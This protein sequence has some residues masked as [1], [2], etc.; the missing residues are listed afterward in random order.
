MHQIIADLSGMGSRVPGYVGHRRAFEYVKQHFEQIG[1]EDIEVE[2]HTVT[3]PI[4]KGASLTLADTG[5]EIA[6]Y[7]FGPTIYKR[8]LY[9]V[10]GFRGHLFMGARGHFQNSMAKRSKAALS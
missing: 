9:P 8:P 5:E 4:D 2:E 1:L 3:V 6:V 7:V 10:L